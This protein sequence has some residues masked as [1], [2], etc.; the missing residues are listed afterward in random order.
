MRQETSPI[1]YAI[2]PCWLGSLLVAGSDIGL[3]AVLLGDDA[4][5]L[6][7]DLQSRF[8][9]ATP[10][11]DDAG[12]ARVVAEV[13]H[14]VE[15]PA[16]RCEV[17]LDPRGTPFERRVWQA[18]REIPAG[19][20]ATYSD[21]AARLDVAGASREVGEACAANLLAVVVPCHRV[22]R[23]NGGLGGYRWGPR[24]KRALLAREASAGRGTS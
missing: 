3:A 9:E 7:R 6:V 17:P 8:P 15:A 24:R 4:D 5:A 2:R 14:L 16:G 22:V 18:L 21:I 1:R 13:A 12:F 10:A 20:T 19:A 11:D 23:K